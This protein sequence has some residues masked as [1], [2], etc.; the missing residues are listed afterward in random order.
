MV[1]R[2]SYFR[3]DLSMPNDIFIVFKY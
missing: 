2:I 3:S 1:C